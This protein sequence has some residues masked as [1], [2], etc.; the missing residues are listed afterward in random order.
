MKLRLVAVGTRLPAWVNAGFEEYARR[1]PRANPLCLVEVPTARRA[2]RNTEQICAEEGKRLLAKVNARDWVVALDVQGRTLS[3]EKL[4]EKLDGWRMQGCDV[5]FL[6]GGA[7][8]LAEDCLTRAD[9]SV[10]LSAF[11]FPHG[12]V[13]VIL[14][15]Q[16]YRAWTLLAGHP[17]HRA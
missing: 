16:L 12:L 2:G 8:G 11:T 3:T 4:A 7:D 15:E 10:S 17:Y 5:T 9:E 14:A 1:L 6:I 13:R